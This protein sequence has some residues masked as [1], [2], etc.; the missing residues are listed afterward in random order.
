MLTDDERRLLEEFEPQCEAELTRL[1][2]SSEEREWIFAGTGS[3][4]RPTRA[5]YEAMLAAFRALP[6]GMGVEK[7]CAEV[8][9]FDYFQSRRS[10]LES[11]AE[12]HS[13]RTA[14]RAWL[15]GLTG[16][17][18]QGLVVDLG[19]GRG[20]DLR[21]LAARHE[22][23]G[24]RFVGVDSAAE[25]LADASMLLGADAR[26]SL[27]CEPL[28]ARLPFDDGSVDL[29]YSHNLLEC[30]SDP[31]AFAREATRVLRPGGRLVVGHWDWDSQ[32]FDGSDKALIRRLVHAYADWQQA[33]MAHADGWLGRRLWG[34]FHDSGLLDGAVH[35]RVLTNTVYSS[36]YF[37]Y[38]NARALGALARRGLVPA[39]DYERFLEDQAALAAAGRYF[40]A[41]TGFAYTAHR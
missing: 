20:E 40:Y 6:D 14:H 17:V 19:C 25:P 12:L 38:E 4:T 11:D 30:L 29:L 35:A 23:P 22:A 8:F 7:F 39:A 36:E 26:V 21:L 10:V 15:V 28:D 1:G 18:E 24:V 5:A 27:R 37:G 2:L 9:G 33:W 32:M 3:D 31:S 13:D 41:I 34:V 16:N